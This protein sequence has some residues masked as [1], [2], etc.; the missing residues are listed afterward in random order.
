MSGPEGVRFIEVHCIM[1][2]L[3][4]FLILKYT[5][6]TILLHKTG[7]SWASIWNLSPRNE[8]FLNY[9]ELPSNWIPSN[10]YTELPLYRTPS[11]PNMVYGPKP[12]YFCMY[13]AFKLESHRLNNIRDFCLVGFTIVYSKMVPLIFSHAQRRKRTVYYLSVNIWVRALGPCVLLLQSA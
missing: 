9:R 2:R 11:I 7:N 3:W 13:K 12:T 1:I 5:H 6:V 4:T 8:T 10:L